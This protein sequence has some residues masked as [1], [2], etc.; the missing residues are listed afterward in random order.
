MQF[1]EDTQI[2]GQENMKRS[3]KK[4]DNI[5]I[6]QKIKMV[7]SSR[8]GFLYCWKVNQLL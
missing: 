5:F 3:S 2:V 4:P 1:K 8:K 7:T 6:Q